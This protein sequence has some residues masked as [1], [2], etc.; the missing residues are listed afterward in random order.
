MN[1]I[2]RKKEAGSF[3]LD[4][5]VKHLALQ[6]YSESEIRPMLNILLSEMKTQLMKG[7]R[8]GLKNVVTLEPVRRKSRMVKIYGKPMQ[9]GPTIAIRTRVSAIMQNEFKVENDENIIINREMGK[10]KIKK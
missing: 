4:K 1:S 9:S 3:G 7:N 2:R 5:W 8:I 10:I 6:G